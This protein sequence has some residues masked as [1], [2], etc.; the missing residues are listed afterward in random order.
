MYVNGSQSYSHRHQKSR[1]VPLSAL[2]HEEG[3]GS[4]D[5]N[6]GGYE[7]LAQ[8]HAKGWSDTLPRS[9]WRPGTHFS[10]GRVCWWDSCPEHTQLGVIGTNSSKFFI[11]FHSLLTIDGIWCIEHIFCEVITSQVQPFLYVRGWRTSRVWTQ[12]MEGKI[13]SFDAH[14]ACGWWRFC[15]DTE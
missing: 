10:V 12:C 9:R 11:L 3:R 6:K 15:P 4:F 7:M 13:Y 8:M 2:S 5:G 1:T 14:F